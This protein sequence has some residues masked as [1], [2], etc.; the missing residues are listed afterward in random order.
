MIQ[1]AAQLLRTS[2]ITPAL[3]AGAAQ[4]QV[5]EPDADQRGELARG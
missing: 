2:V 3:R 4:Q 1:V 5:A